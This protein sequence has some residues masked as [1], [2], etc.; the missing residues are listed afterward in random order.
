[1]FKRD[2][3]RPIYWTLDGSDDY[4]LLILLG[5]EHLTSVYAD[6]AIWAKLQMPLRI[7]TGGCLE[8]ERHTT[9]Q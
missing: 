1:M 6:G 9:T 7:I 2:N 3:K 4:L 8:E 5:W